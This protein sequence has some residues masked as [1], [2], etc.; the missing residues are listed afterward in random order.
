MKVSAIGVGLSKMCREPVTVFF[1][2]A[3]G[4][5]VGGVYARPPTVMRISIGEEAVEATRARLAA[6]LKR[7]PKPEE[8][9]GAI[10]SVIDSEV[11][12]R[13]A[14]RLGLARRDPIVRRRMIQKME[15]VLEQTATADDESDV[16]L[17]AWYAENL[18]PFTSPE[19][20]SFSQ[21]QL[22]EVTQNELVVLESRA[23]ELGIEA[24]SP[25]DELGARPSVH[26]RAQRGMSERET[27]RRFG[28]QVARVIF[29][30][31]RGVWRPASGAHGWMLVRVDRVLAAGPAD[32]KHVRAQVREMRAVELRE[33]ARDRKLK[34]LRTTYEIEVA[35]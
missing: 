22:G 1:V 26:S 4:V 15:M 35:Q 27:G 21:M 24:D 28:E 13:E 29:E 30:S 7:A 31:P 10:E 16:A 32:F 3:A 2:I 11:L 6:T 25:G 8:L 14:I 18:D 17:R 23:N 20:R 12:Y 5:M 9:E 33:Q 34:R 19:R